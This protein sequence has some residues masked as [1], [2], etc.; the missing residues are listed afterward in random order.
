MISTSDNKENEP[1]VD[2]YSV[3]PGTSTSPEPNDTEHQNSEKHNQVSRE[4]T[5]DVCLTWQ[6]QPKVLQRSLHLHSLIQSQRTISTPCIASALHMFSSEGEP[7]S[8]YILS[9]VYAI[10]LQV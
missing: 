7:F 4:I 6:T 3:D 1:I 8:G 2:E 9:Y 10:L 5:N